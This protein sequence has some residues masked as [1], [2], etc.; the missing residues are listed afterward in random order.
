MV[1]VRRADAF[2]IGRLDAHDQAALAA[3]GEVTAAELTE[4]AI[5]RIEALDPELLSLGRP[6]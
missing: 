6:G 1:I 5:V 4:A 3:R 2:A